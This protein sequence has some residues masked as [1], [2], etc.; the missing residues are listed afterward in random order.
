M[1][2]LVSVPLRPRL[3]PITRSQLLHEA[4][5]E[6][7]ETCSP[8]AFRLGMHSHSRRD[9][10]RSPGRSRSR[11]RLHWD[12]PV[13]VARRSSAPPR[14]P[15]RSAALRRSERPS[16]LLNRSRAS[17]RVWKRASERPGRI[18]SEDAQTRH[19]DAGNPAPINF[20]PDHSPSDLLRHGRA[21]KHHP[22]V[23]GRTTRCAP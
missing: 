6:C 16:R 13:S 19:D 14:C 1:T 8:Y 18:A 7:C 2:S 12:E 22:G 20:A 5:G 17:S 10:R 21:S 15:D 23:R 11:R 9:S 3:P 4:R